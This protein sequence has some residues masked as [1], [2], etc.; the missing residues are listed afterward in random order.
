MLW[1]LIPIGF[2]GIAFMMTTY[3]ISVMTNMLTIAAIRHYYGKWAARM[4]GITT[5]L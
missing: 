1:L 4:V 3:R 5:F 2:M